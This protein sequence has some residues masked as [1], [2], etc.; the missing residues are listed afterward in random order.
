MYLAKVKKND[1]NH[2]GKLAH[3]DVLA[4]C[5]DFLNEKTCLVYLGEHLRVQVNCSTNATQKWPGRGLSTLGAELNQCIK[6]PSWQ[7]RKERRTSATLFF[8]DC[9]LKKRMEKEAYQNGWYES[10][11]GEHD[12]IS[13]HI[14][15]LRKIKKNALK[16]S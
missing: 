11:H 4:D 7:I 3:S 1:P 8:N 5:P 10:S 6:G 13:W 12:T 15:M 2:K 9:Q 14:F 16:V